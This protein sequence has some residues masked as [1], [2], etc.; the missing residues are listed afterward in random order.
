MKPKGQNEH[1]EGLLEYLEDIIGTSRLKEPIDEA[2]KEVDTINDEREEKLTML[3]IVE[4]DKNS[5]EV[6]LQL[7]YKRIKRKKR[8]NILI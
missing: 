6:R 5:L 3:K 1:E 7:T 8:W 2:R 4:K